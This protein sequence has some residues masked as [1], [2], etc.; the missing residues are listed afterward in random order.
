VTRSRRIHTA[1]PWTLVDTLGA[2]DGRRL[3]ESD[4]ASKRHPYLGG[5]KPQR[6]QRRHR[7][8]SSPH[9]FSGISSIASRDQIRCTQLKVRRT[10]SRSPNV[11]DG[12]RH[13]FLLQIRGSKTIHVGERSF[14]TER[15]LERFFTG[16]H[17]NVS[18]PEELG[19]KRGTRRQARG[20]RVMR[21]VRP[22]DSLCERTLR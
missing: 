2:F 15:E 10:E 19:E 1:L 6:R 12:K 8:W 3:A 11:A 4:D 20:A 9:R 21:A 14:V 18:L 7:S 22:S 13:N 16:G 17:R 5:E